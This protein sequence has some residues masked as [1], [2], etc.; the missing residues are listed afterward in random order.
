MRYI[1]EKL[2][3][4]SWK[5]KEKKKGGEGGTRGSKKGNSQVEFPVFIKQ[6][7]HQ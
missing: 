4:S 7:A 6:F 1:L 3:A 5:K 2:E